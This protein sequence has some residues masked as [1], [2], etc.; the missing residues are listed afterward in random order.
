MHIT[1]TCISNKGKLF[2]TKFLSSW[3]EGWCWLHVFC[4]MVKGF[5]FRTSLHKSQGGKCTSFCFQ[6][7]DCPKAQPER[8]QDTLTVCFKARAVVTHPDL[9]LYQAPSCKFSIIY[10]VPV[11]LWLQLEDTSLAPFKSQNVFTTA[12]LPECFNNS[13]HIFLCPYS[14]RRQT[15]LA[16]RADLQ[17]THMAI[18]PEAIKEKNK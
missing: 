18:R 15:V 5:G 9:A 13:E 3:P 8:C 17:T 1:Q 16:E 10:L 2:S 4:T 7:P 11:Q 12:K 6:G 14:Q